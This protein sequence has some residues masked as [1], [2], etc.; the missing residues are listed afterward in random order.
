L[1]EALPCVRIAAWFG[2]IRLAGRWGLIPTLGSYAPQL[3][4]EKQAR[5]DAMA[6]RTQTVTTMRDEAF[7]VEETTTQV[8]ATGSLGDR[9]LAVLSANG[10]RW[11]PWL[12]PDFPMQKFKRM[13]LQ[14]QKDLTTL[15]SNSWQIFADESSHF[16]QFNQPE[17]VSGPTLCCPLVRS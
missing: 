10:P 12:P 16:I 3:S 17:L 2:V 6:Y 14:L 1:G 9:P 8:Q 7:A 4:A 5:I 11:M 15:S 13:W